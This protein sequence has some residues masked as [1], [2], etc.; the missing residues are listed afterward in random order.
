MFNDLES[1]YACNIV[2]GFSRGISKIEKTNREASDLIN[3]TQIFDYCEQIV[4]NSQSNGIIALSHVTHAQDA[5]SAVRKTTLRFICKGLESNLIPSKFRE[6]VWRLIEVCVSDIDPRPE[7]EAKCSEDRDYYTIAI[8]A[9][10]SYA[11]ETAIHY[12]RW[13]LRNSDSKDNGDF[14]LYPEIQGLLEYYMDFVNE[15][16]LAVRSI[17]GAFTPQLWLL[18]KIWFQ[19]NVNRIFPTNDIQHF[20]SA[21]RTYITFCHPFNVIFELTKIHYMHELKILNALTSEEIKN[22]SSSEKLIEHLM[23]FY[24][25]G[26]FEVTDEIM[27]FV[28]DSPHVELRAYALSFIGRTIKSSTDEDPEAEEKMDKNL[29]PR[30]LTY[31]DHRVSNLENASLD[32]RQELAKIGW[33]IQSGFFPEIKMLN[34]IKKLSELE[35]SL[36]PNYAVFKFLNNLADSEP[37]LVAECLYGQVTLELKKQWFHDFENR[38]Y[39]TL[40]TLLQSQDQQ[41]VYLATDT[42][43]LL[44]AKGAR[45]FSDLIP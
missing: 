29:R 13:I 41:V 8:N 3:W 15:P 32:Q 33:W 16:S 23:T 7:R 40:K 45:N 27:T 9:P 43:N 24:G 26:L 35:V 1:T 28:F 21:F 18:D 10:R 14:K 44:A 4:I 37:L 19:Q 38:I 25:R 39:D 34:T 36:E 2:D 6:N 20:E 5:L 11:I 12:G 30:F 42:I 17:Y 22:C 31:L